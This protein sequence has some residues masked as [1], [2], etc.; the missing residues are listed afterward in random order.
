MRTSKEAA[1][2]PGD[3]KIYV[4]CSLTHA[5][6]AFRLAVEALKQELSH[7]YEV[8]NF[9]GLVDGTAQDVYRWDIQRCVA[10]ADIFVAICDHASLGLGY[11]IGTA[12]EKHQKPVLAVAHQA[13]HISR[14]ILGI[15]APNFSFKRY[16]DFAEIKQLLEV[17]ITAQT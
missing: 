13:T 16:K 8:F 12:V 5:P 4:G 15:D 17:F 9:L 2:P 11:E 14:L 1:K 7:N 3:T 10:N 6:E